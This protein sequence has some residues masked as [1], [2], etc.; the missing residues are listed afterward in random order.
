MKKFMHILLLSAMIFCICT[1]VAF[2]D[3]GSK[4]RVEINLKNAP[5]VEYYLDLLYQP[6]RTASMYDNLDKGA[7][8]NE[9]MLRALRAYEKDGWYAAM[10]SGTLTPVF[11]SLTAEDGRHVFSYIGVP[12]EF[13]I[14]IVTSGGDVKISRPVKRRTM[15]VSLDVDFTDMSVNK[16]SARNMYIVQFAGSLSATLIIEFI[17]LL[18][19][20][21]NIKEN[22]KVFLLANTFTQLVFSALFSTVFLFGGT[23][24]TLLA[25]IPLEICVAAAE[26]FIYKRNLKGKSSKINVMYALSANIASAAL[27]YWNL[28]FIL[29][30]MTKLIR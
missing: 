13:K 1:P 22:I 19:F 9:D 12:D 15:E 30:L 6:S 21:Y 11:G 17:I 26:I 8:Y 14:I 10:A 24:G 2:A 27:T 23:F 28:E 18:L 29:T 16:K 3:F 5:Q 25:F 7:E 20:R 4:P